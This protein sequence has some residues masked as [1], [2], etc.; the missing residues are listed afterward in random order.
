MCE[1]CNPFISNIPIDS[2][3]QRASEFELLPHHTPHQFFPPIPTGAHGLPKR[4][5][6][7]FPLV[8]PRARNTPGSPQLLPITMANGRIVRDR[9][10]CGRKRKFR[11]RLV[12]QPVC[13]T[14]FP[15]HLFHRAIPVRSGD[16][17]LGCPSLRQYLRTIEKH[18]RHLRPQA[19]FRTERSN[20]N[21]NQRQHNDRQDVMF[22]A[23]HN[24]NRGALPRPLPCRCAPATRCSDR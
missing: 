2:K 13:V 15:L 16:S 14:I 12:W 17:L 11:R 10:H 21:D 24:V 7:E 1:Q 19:E 4:D 9:A 3:H 8:V 18:R 20:G 6:A 5:K 22:S 23:D